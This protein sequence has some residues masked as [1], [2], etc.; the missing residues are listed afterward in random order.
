MS[1]QVWEVFSGPEEYFP[2][3]NPVENLS[4]GC[5]LVCDLVRPHVRPYGKSFLEADNVISW[6]TGSRA[7]VLPFGFGLSFTSFD[8]QIVSAPAAPL[9]L[10]AVRGALAAGRGLS[11]LAPMVGVAAPLAGYTVNVSNTGKV[12]AD[13]VV[14]G[15][16]KPP[17]A[18]AGGVPLQ[19]LF[20]FERVHVRAGQ[21]IA[22]NLS[23]SFEDFTLVDAGGGRCV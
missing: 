22:V 5:F 16:L 21:T 1:D 3:W 4:W 10:A 7:Q 2:L 19:T 9:S 23:P 15:F 11:G 13:D 14:L 12:D 18:G 6:G 8:Y 17:G 20:A